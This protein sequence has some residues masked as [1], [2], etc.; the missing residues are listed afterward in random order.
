MPSI[1]LENIAL[2]QIEGHTSPF[3]TPFWA[4]IKQYS[5]WESLAFRLTI[6]EVEQDVTLLVLI[7][8]I[9]VVSLAYVP[10]GPAIDT[11]TC[12]VSSYLRQLSHALKAFLPWHTIYI[13]Y[14]LPWNQDEKEEYQE[15][16]GSNIRSCK[17]SIQPEGTVQIPLEAGYEAV[18]AGYRERARRNIRKNQALGVT[19]KSYSGDKA[20]FDA[21]YEV[22]R[23]SARRDGFA[24]RPADYIQ[25]FVDWKQYQYPQGTKRRYPELPSSNQVEGSLYL[26]YLG[27]RLIGGAIIISTADVAL[28]LFGSSLRIDG[29]SG[30]YLI[31]DYAIQK[32]I[33]KGCKIYDLHGI[34]GPEERMAHLD[35]LRLFK[36][37]FGG[38]TYYRY[39]ST[40]YLYHPFLWF[41]YSKIELMRLRAQRLRQ[42]KKISQQFS[43]SRDV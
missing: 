12:D 24:A 40:D 17:E 31:Q 2:D 27:E 10:F 33:E 39:P 38:K 22:Y 4:A 37:S 16:T 13:R 1:R 42:P 29:V 21:W 8:R 3:Q 43:V 32:A 20:E 7:R 30:S 6:D 23:E 26:A 18:K 34:S 5:G 28:Y 36:R 19:V 15:L 14:D 9:G 25:Q 41:F 11:L 35:S